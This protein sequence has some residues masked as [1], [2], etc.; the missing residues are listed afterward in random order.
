VKNSNHTT[1]VF[2]IN[3]FGTTFT[4]LHQHYNIGLYLWYV[5]ITMKGYQHN[6]T[7]KY[8]VNS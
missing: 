6:K 5:E 8:A 7:E 4:T 1:F 2:Q 3:M